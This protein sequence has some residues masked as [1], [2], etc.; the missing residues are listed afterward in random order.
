MS[1]CMSSL[2]HLLSLAACCTD[3][4]GEVQ[5]PPVH[6]DNAA[7]HETA[8]CR[9]SFEALLTA[10]QTRKSACRL[11]KQ[12]ALSHVP[13]E[14]VAPNLAAPARL[15]DTFLDSPP[16][17]AAHRLPAAGQDHQRDRILCGN[18]YSFR[19]W[20]HRDGTK[21]HYSTKDDVMNFITL[22]LNLRGF[23]LCCTYVSYIGHATYSLVVAWLDLE[24]V[25]D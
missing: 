21:S 3:L 12:A 5:L 24:L 2:V 8:A 11:Q 19:H 20:D 22:N 23:W 16:A 4:F 7:L 18:P 9:M 15:F 1:R 13:G 14:S 6:S 17:H 25:V 10:L